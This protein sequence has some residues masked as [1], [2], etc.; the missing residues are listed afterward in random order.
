L[1]V[2]IVPFSGPLRVLHGLR[3]SP[4]LVRELVGLQRVMVPNTGLYVFAVALL[5]IVS[6]VGLILLFEEGSGGPIRTVCDPLWW[7]VET[8]TTVGY[9]DM[10]P[11]TAA[12]RVVAG[13]VMAVGCAFSGSSPPR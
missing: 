6:G 2:V 1:D 10:Y 12:G 7:A 9:G 8:I 5:T 13:V 3:F 11:V 4:F